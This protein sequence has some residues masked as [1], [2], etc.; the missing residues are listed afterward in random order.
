VVQRPT[1][2]S[3]AGGR[4]VEQYKNVAD[5]ETRSGDPAK[6]KRA[7]GGRNSPSDSIMSPSASTTAVEKAD[8]ILSRI[9][10]KL[11]QDLSVEYQVNQLVQE[12][13]DNTN[14]ARIFSGW[15]SWM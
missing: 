10:Q 12:A 14:L 15:Q 3:G 2:P 1:G 11:R 9:R 13:R 8:R 5:A 7:Q 4:I 6:I